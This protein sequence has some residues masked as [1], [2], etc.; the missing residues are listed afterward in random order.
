MLKRN[1]FFFLLIC[2]SVLCF[3][4]QKQVGKKLSAP[5][6]YFPSAQ[7][8]EQRTP[9][10]SGLDAGRI[11]EAIAIAKAAETKNPGNMQTSH[12]QTFGKEPFGEGIGPFVERG[13]PTGII[14]Y[15]GYIV[16]AWGEPLR[17]DMT[18]S[19]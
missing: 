15:K 10:E 16:A 3:C 19:V 17:C 1:G 11:Q 8:W 6:P 7:N 5:Q 2:S 14:V 9:A 12:Y 4:Q 18:H 13:D